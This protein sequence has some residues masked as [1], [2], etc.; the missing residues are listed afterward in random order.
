MVHFAYTRLLLRRLWKFLAAYAAVLVVAAVGFYVL[1]SYSGWNDVLNS[2]YWAMITLS[3]IGYGDIT[4]NNPDA[5]LFVTGIAAVEVF[6]TA[7]LV[8]VVISVVQETAQHRLL[9]TLGTDFKDHIVV[10][11]YSAVGQAA[12]RE[13][14]ADDQKVAI[15]TE[16]ASEVPTIHNL[17]NDK[18]LF[19]TYGPPGDPEILKRVNIPVAHSVIVSTGEDTTTLV[20]A[21]NVRAMNPQIRI[22]VSVGRPELKQTLKAAGVTYVASPADMGGRLCA[23]AA[24]RPEVANMVEDLTSTAYGA[25]MEEFI[26]TATTPIST[27]TLPEVESTVRKATDCI[28]I[29]YARRQPDGEYT[30]VLNPPST[31]RFQPTDALIVVGTLD[32]LHRMQR[33]I[34]VPQGR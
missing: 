33:W 34:G 30:T 31:F 3:T 18:R 28:V 1:E 12:V 8:S 4:P 22:V 16:I 11:G 9:G 10:L 25:D 14:L 19:V 26:L 5:R 32:N 2:F 29:G 27:Q 13:L 15:V 21:L 20:A 6:L 24:F 7:Y 17:A 23:D